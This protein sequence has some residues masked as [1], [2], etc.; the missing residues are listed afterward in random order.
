MRA[1]GKPRRAGARGE[2]AEG[3]RKQNET[4]HQRCIVYQKT[5]PSAL[6]VYDDHSVA[7]AR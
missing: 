7:G 1:P 4:S 3:E 6:G 2:D 5:L